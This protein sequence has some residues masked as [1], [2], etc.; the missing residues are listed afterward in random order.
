[1]YY[2]VP[3]FMNLRVFNEV[4]KSTYIMYHLVAGSFVN[5]FLQIVWKSQI[6]VHLKV[7]S[8]HSVQAV[9]KPTTYINMLSGCERTH[10]EYLQIKCLAQEG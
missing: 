2:L 1:M 3:L 10:Y 9:R 8:L 4:F 5:S 6:A 7:I